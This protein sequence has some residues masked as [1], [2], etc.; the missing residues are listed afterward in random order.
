M[1]DKLI[2]P[3]NVIDFDRTR[4]ATDNSGGSD[5]PWLSKRPL[6]SIFLCRQ[7]DFTGKRPAKELI[8]FQLTNRTASGL[9]VYIMD[10]SNSQIYTVDPIAFSRDMELFEIIEEGSDE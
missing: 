5:G 8:E 6:D 7:R 3:N 1:N 4:K 2:L 9:S 10:R